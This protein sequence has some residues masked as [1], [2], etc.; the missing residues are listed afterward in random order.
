[1]FG[2]LVECRRVVPACGAGFDVAAGLLKEHA[3]RRSAEPEGRRDPGG[4]TVTR[5]GT[6]Y[7]YTFR[8]IRARTQGFR[9]VDLFK[10]VHLASHRMGRGAD[11]LPNFGFDDHAGSPRRGRAL[12]LT[13]APRKEIVYIYLSGSDGIGCVKRR[14]SVGAALE[15][16]SD[17]NAECQIMGAAYQRAVDEAGA[18]QACVADERTVHHIS[19]VQAAAH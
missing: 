2:K 5:G 12:I 9:G 3:E 11:E 17:H 15:N 10:Y 7:Q 16:P 6:D 1:L 4:Q 13:Y 18:G 19:A 14:Y 8:S